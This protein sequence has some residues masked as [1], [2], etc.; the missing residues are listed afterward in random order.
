[1]S[2]IKTIK[3]IGESDC[4]LACIAMVVGQ[5]IEK[6]FP[7]KFREEI[8]VIET[9][10]GDNIDKAFNYAGLE[11]DVDYWSIAFGMTL[12]N[13]QTRAMLRGRK[14]LL[15]V[16]SLNYQRGS[17]IIFW[18]GE[19]IHD[20]SNKQIYQWLHQCNPEYIWIFNKG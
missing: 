5:T 19:N 3:Q 16:P 15:Q 17:H 12:W 14:V 6:T 7:E 18:D 11:R 1:M 2:T 20:P 13:F 10:T 4:F 8:E 9:T